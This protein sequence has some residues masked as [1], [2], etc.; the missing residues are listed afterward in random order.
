MQALGADAEEGREHMS[1]LTAGIFDLMFVLF[2]AVFWRLFGWKVRLRSLD[3]I[4]RS[5]MPV[6]NIALIILLAVNG[7]ALCLYP[8]EVLQ[9]GLGRFLLGGMTAFWVIRA[10]VQQPYFGWRHP[11]SIA[12][13]LVFIIG[14]GLHAY[15]LWVSSL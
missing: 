4:N 13:Q 8:D 10:A 12:L 9:T 7:L 5:L 6:M 1:V 14:A 11:A 3:S 2:H 15:S